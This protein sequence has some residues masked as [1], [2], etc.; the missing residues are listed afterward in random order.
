MSRNCF[1]KTTM[2]IITALS[3]ITIYKAVCQT[4]VGADIVVSAPALCKLCGQKYQNAKTL[5]RNVYPHNNG[6]SHVLFE[7]KEADNYICENCGAS[8]SSLK[9]LTRNR[10]PHEEGMCH[11]PYRNGVCHQYTCRW[12]GRI[13]VSLK[14]MTRNSCTKHPLVKGTHRP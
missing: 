6:G 12:C 13:Y 8:Y 14:D 4:T 3:V 7:G 5:L 2:P 9:D 1:V 11:V 10:C